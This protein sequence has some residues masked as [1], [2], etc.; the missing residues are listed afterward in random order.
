MAVSLYLMELVRDIQGSKGDGLSSK[1]YTTPWRLKDSWLVSSV[2]LAG[3]EGG[4]QGEENGE[5]GCLLEDIR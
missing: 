4:R 5:H 1:Q 3:Q 2:K